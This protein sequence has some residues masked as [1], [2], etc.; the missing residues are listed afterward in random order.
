MSMSLSWTAKSTSEWGADDIAVLRTREATDRGNR[1]V[2]AIL[3]VNDDAVL[4]LKA[5]LLELAAAATA[6]A[7]AHRERMS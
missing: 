7:G 2:A 6:L 5:E 3:Q 1:N 4:L